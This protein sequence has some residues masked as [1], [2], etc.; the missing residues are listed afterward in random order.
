MKNLK[1]SI[2]LDNPFRL[3]YHKARAVIANVMYGFPSKG[4][5]I[6]W[7]TGTNWKTTTSNIIWKWLL[8]AWEKVFMFTTVNYIIDGKEYQNK[9]KMTSPMHL[10]FK[11]YFTMQKKHD[12]NMPLSKQLLMV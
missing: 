2:A 1:K 7:V 12:V 3:L 4:M 6:I 11:N 10:L 9:T 5:V 8:E